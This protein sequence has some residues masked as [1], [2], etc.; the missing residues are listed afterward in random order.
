MLVDV[1]FATTKTVRQVNSVVN[2]WSCRWYI[3]E[4]NYNFLN[5]KSYKKS[6]K[7]PK[8]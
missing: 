3:F 5:L 4:E 1:Q 6:L 2:H 8:G 7:I